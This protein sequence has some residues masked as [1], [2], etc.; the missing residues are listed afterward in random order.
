[1]PPGPDAGKDGGDGGAVG[2]GADG[3]NDAG[4]ATGT[5]PTDGGC[6]GVFCD[7]FESSSAGHAP[8]LPWTVDLS[9]S[10]DGNVLID[11]TM[12]HTPNGSQSLKLSVAANPSPA[13]A[14]WA[15]AML[16]GAPALPLTTMYGRMWVR[17]DQLAYDNGN[18]LHV[19]NIEASG[20]LAD[21]TTS[22][23]DNLGMYYY[24]GTNTQVGYTT[25][26]GDGS[27]G[28]D[29]A[30]SPNGGAKPY[31]TPA[32][33]TWICY[34]WMVG[35]PDLMEVWFD[36]TEV[37]HVDQQ[38]LTADGLADWPAPVQ[39]T[40]LEIGWAQWW[41]SNVPTTMWVDDFVLGTSRIGCQ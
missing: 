41:N 33:N 29:D 30:Y 9:R 34:E 22:A 5:P 36:G 1:M 7:D 15:F 4:V 32:V 26:N 39:F 37:I 24:E 19:N 11:S 13:N 35:P 3:G 25:I 10:Q 21:H 28:R 27:S 2:P 40:T 31:V 23:S 18:Y 14:V 17:F 6:P 12:N 38:A 8:S 16:S 20:L